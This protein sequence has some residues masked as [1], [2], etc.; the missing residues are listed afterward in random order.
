MLTTPYCW[1][2]WLGPNILVFYVFVRVCPTPRQRN[3]LGYE[4]VCGMTRYS[5]VPA[6][7]LGRGHRRT[8]RHPGDREPDAGPR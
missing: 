3:A 5:I 7:P 2:D 8:E 1:S 6:G 4:Q